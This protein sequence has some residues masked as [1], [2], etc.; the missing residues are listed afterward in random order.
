[1]TLFHGGEIGGFCGL[2]AAVTGHRRSGADRNSGGGEEAARKIFLT[3]RLL[4]LAV[5]QRYASAI[6]LKRRRAVNRL[7][8]HAVGLA[9]S[10]SARTQSHAKCL[11]ERHALSASARREV[12]SARPA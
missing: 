10:G 5:T 3:I 8:L 1:M 7:V 11:S 6:G 12:S 4:R 9:K 2:E